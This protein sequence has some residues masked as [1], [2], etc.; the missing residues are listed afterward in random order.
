MHTEV[1]PISDEILKAAEVSPRIAKMVELRRM[2]AHD[3]IEAHASGTL[4]K[5]KRVGFS[6][7][8]HYRV[9]RVAWEFGYE[10]EMLPKTYVT[11][12]DPISAGDC[13]A[14]TETGW[15]VERMMERSMFPSDIFEVKYIIAEKAAGKGKPPG[16]REGLGVLVKQT[17]AIWMPKGHLVF[18]FIS[19]FDP[20]T[21][22]WT[23][24]VSPF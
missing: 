24:P 20:E 6:W 23:E 15:H 11:F 21:H 12:N 8:S 9:E 3:W 10:L 16:R 14:S 13:A 22:T 1:V 19:M 4:R 17:S 5:N 7:T 18:A 2:N